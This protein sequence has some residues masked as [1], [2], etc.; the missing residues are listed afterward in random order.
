MLRDQRHLLGYLLPI[1][2][3]ACCL[4]PL[5]ASAQ[6]RRVNDR[7]IVNNA[8][9]TLSLTSESSVIKTC[10]E[11]DGTRVRLNA[12]ASS[13]DGLPIKYRW[14]TAAGRIIGEG[15][16]IVWDLAGVEPG[17]Y[18]AFVEIETGDREGECQ[19]FASTNILVNAC[20]VVKPVCPA[21]TVVCPTNIAIDQPLTF[22]SN[23][24]GGTGTSAP[25]YTW[26]ISIGRI[27][28]GQGTPT[29]KVDTTGLA[30]ET[31]TATLAIG[32]FADNCADSCTVSIPLPQADCRKFDEFP[33]IARNDEKARLD[34]LAVQLQND[35][36]STAYVVV[37]PGRSGRPG[38]TQRHS[39]RIVDYLVNSRHI[40]T[41]RVVTL[42][43]AERDELM[44]ELSVCPQGV[45][46][47]RP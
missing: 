8:P 40:D 2:L 43:G 46:L 41:R 3:A 37:S 29:L 1:A 21:V 32:G 9:P 36:T 12:Q 17:Y 5:Q 42:V 15:P 27:I 47:P 13:P 28:E 26:T 44:V 20:P 16:S 25:V 45:T 24:I 10:A 39:A 18:K 6:M 4:F 30:G 34:N 38:D 23:V 31:I 19:A 7:E 11:G 22:T 33:S 35:P 14:S